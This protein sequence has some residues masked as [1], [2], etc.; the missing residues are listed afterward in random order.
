MQMWKR[1]HRKRM[2]RESNPSWKGGVAKNTKIYRDRRKALLRENGGL[3]VEVVQRVYEDNIKKFGTLTCYLCLKPISFGK[4]SL[5]HKIPI[6]RGG[7]NL[8][9]NL[10]IVHKRC[11]IIY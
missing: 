10:A 2:L 1:I 4:D 11:N 8:Y 7:T 6:S 3:P 9:E 5:D